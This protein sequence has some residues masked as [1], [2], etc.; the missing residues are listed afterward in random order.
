MRA[1]RC[2]GKWPMAY[3]KLDVPTTFG[4]THVIAS[5]WEGAPVVLLHAFFATAMSWYATVDVL[6]EHHRV[7][8]LTSWERRTGAGRPG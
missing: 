8:A 7:F 4:D 5:G 6:A 3:T 1:T 2:S